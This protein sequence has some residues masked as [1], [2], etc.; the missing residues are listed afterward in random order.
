MSKDLQDMT[1]EELE[2][3]SIELK[4]RK[5]F[6]GERVNDITYRHAVDSEIYYR[7][8]QLGHF[9]DGGGTNNG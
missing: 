8:K 5:D 3:L 1:L 9:Q 2:N 4:V 6:T 7:K